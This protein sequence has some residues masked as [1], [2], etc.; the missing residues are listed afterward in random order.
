MDNQLPA[1]LSAGARSRRPFDWEDREVLVAKTLEDRMRRRQ[2]ELEDAMGSRDVFVP[3]LPDGRPP[4]PKAPMLE[5]EPNAAT[6]ELDCNRNV[7]VAKY[8]PYRADTDTAVAS[9]DV[10][11]E[12]L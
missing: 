11:S 1:A 8:D 9:S 5:P 3:E 12:Y 2:D 7:W 10:F 4:G 6:G